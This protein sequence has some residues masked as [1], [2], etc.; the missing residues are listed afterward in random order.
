MPTP[1]QQYLDELNAIANR[2]GSLEDT[3]IK[4]M[5]AMM[6]ELRS[7]VAAEITTAGGFE[8]FRLDQMRRGLERLIGEFEVRLQTEVRTAFEQT[9]QAGGESVT[10]PFQKIGIGGIF[11]QPSTAQLNTVLDFSAR[12]IKQISDE[13]RAKIDQQV[14]L[15]VLGQK[16]PVDAMKLITQDLGIEARTGVWKKRH[17]PVE[18]I[19]AR[20]ETDLRTE[21]QRT[22]NLSTF[23]QQRQSARRI[24]GLTKSWLGTGDVHTRRSHLQAHIFYKDRPIPVDEPFIIGPKRAK[25][26]YPGDPNGPPEETINCRCRSITHHPALG[27]VGSS[28]DGRIAA[29]L[30]RRAA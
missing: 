11:F 6:K 29:E 18:G 30:K 8:T 2:Y 24:P 13:I 25:L 3:T 19:A 12:L 17:D 26:M 9:Y 15:A 27:R 16:N 4:R 28:L 10:A 1:K 20:A 22:F 7:Q 23:S 14:R 5:L 21:M